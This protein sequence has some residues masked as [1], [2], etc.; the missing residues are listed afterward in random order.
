MVL[1]WTTFCTF[2]AE[3]TKIYTALLLLVWGAPSAWAQYVYYDFTDT[4]VS[5][6]LG[7]A[8]VDF[9]NDSIADLRF[10]LAARRAAS[11]AAINRH[12]PGGLQLV[13]RPCRQ[14]P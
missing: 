2:A 14:I 12:G 9:N 3:M 6:N 4:T 5:T 7:F 10:T 1:A 11:A 8:D 13:F